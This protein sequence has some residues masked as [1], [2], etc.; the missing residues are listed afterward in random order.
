MIILMIT[1]KNYIR[2]KF[3]VR[4][5]TDLFKELIPK[6]SYKSV[7]EKS[8]LLYSTFEINN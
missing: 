1:S 7:K 4:K 8:F 3:M 5:R 6:Q 2:E